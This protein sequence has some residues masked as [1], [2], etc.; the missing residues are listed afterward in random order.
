[1]I[2]K[3]ALVAFSGGLDT[4]FCVPFLRE[5][6]YEVVT[7]TLNSGGF[8]EAELKDIEERALK[9]GSIKHIALDVQEAMYDQI[10]RYQIMANGLYQQSYPLMCSDRYLIAEKLSEY[11]T[12]ENCE[13]VVTG[14]TGQGNDQVRIDVALRILAPH[15]TNLAPIRDHSLT[16]DQ[17]K[18]YLTD[19]GFEIPPKHTSYTKNQNILGVTTSGSEIDEVKEPKDET[20]EL[21]RLTQT[22]QTYAEIEFKQGLPVSLNG[23]QLPG[24][25][26]LK[27][28]NSLAGSHGFGRSHYIG[29]CV[30]GIKGAIWFEAPGILS[31][32]KAHQ[33]LEQL[34]LTKRQRDQKAS[35]D[36]IWAEMVFN[37]QFY[38]PLVQD[39][40]A[41]LE[42]NQKRVTGTV[43]LRFRQNVC[44]AVEIS[45]PCSLIDRKVADYAQRASWTGEEAKAFIKLYGLQSVIAS[46]KK[47]PKE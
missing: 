2:V 5:K 44:A 16:R 27:A 8:S 11:A 43:K 9:L 14:N 23:K 18:K 24:H 20:F 36:A 28:L 34:V 10:I 17:E 41:F 37:G 47:P 4:S 38:D 3:K 33:A 21:T 40:Q 30:V 29:D 15:L 22:G 25:E 31:L 42:S 46:S 7:L 35:L 1:M 32:I 13:A 39:I 45:S 6:G 19:H 12:K 26:I